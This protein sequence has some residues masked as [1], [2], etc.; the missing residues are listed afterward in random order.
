MYFSINV[1]CQASSLSFATV[2]FLFRFS[3]VYVS[4]KSEE[5]A[6]NRGHSQNPVLRI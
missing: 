6:T 5:Y 1:N 2:S 3:F 4:F